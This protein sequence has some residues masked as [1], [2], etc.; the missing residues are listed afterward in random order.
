MKAL[1]TPL[2]VFVSTLAISQPFGIQFEV[3]EFNGDSILT[4]DWVIMNDPVWKGGYF[5]GFKISKVEGL[6]AMQLQVTTG[7]GV[8]SIDEGDLLQIKLEDDS[9]INL[10]CLE[11]SM[12]GIGEGTYRF[13]GSA[14]MGINAF[15]LL[16]I[17]QLTAL[18]SNKVYKARLTTNQGYL[19]IEPEKDKYKTDMLKYFRSFLIFAKV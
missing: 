19:E 16:T 9:V 3:D 14:A 18:T 10:K 1:L 2:L 8:I 13:R 17:D 15:F 5:A 11:Y 6:M 4:S 7:G 12:S